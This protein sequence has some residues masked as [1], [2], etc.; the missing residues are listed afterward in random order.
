MFDDI[1][2]TLDDVLQCSTIFRLRSTIF[3]DI[4]TTF[5][6]VSTMFDDVYQP[7]VEHCRALSSTVEHCR[8]LSGI[9]GHC[10]ALSGTSMSGTSMSGT[11][12]SSKFN[13]LLITILKLK[14]EI[15]NCPTAECSKLNF[16]AARKINFLGLHEI[17]H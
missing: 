1:S 12:M 13:N 5:D 7:I 2:T 6:V 3:N 9:V 14:K 17:N 4:P 15:L 16:R 8:A 11:S 10:R